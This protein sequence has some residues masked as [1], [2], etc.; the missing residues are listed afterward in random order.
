MT[1]LQSKNPSLEGLTVIEN[2]SFGEERALYNSKDVLLNN[3]KFEGTIQSDDEINEND[4]KKENNFINIYR[5][6]S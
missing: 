3:I 5:N 2:K 6:S 1:K 4:K